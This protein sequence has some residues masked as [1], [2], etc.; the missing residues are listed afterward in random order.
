MDFDRDRYVSVTPI[1]QSYEQVISR[2]I[3]SF[4]GNIGLIQ[5]SV[6][7]ENLF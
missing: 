7:N 4:Y 1:P 2:K 5:D 3:R 6:C